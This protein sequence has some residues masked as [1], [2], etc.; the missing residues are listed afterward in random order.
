MKCPNPDFIA[1]PEHSRVL[2]LI[3]QDGK[4]KFNKKNIG[5]VEKSC[6]DIKKES[7]QDL[8]KA[9]ANEGPISVAIDVSHSSF[10][11]YK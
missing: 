3:I 4:C 2:Y 5:A 9:V 11:L 1:I 10:Q 6:M 8:Q 7:E